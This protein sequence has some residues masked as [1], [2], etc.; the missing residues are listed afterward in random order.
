MTTETPWIERTR[1]EPLEPELPIIDPHHHFWFR[2]NNRYILDD[3]LA[4]VR[5]VGKV[6]VRYGYGSARTHR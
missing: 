4:D 1:E 2:P 3:L 6:P 5:P